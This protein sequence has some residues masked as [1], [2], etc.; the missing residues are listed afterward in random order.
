MSLFGYAAMT[1]GVLQGEL[2][3]K[4]KASL[5]F[6]MNHCEN[7]PDFVTESFVQQ[8]TD[9]VHV[10]HIQVNEIEIPERPHMLLFQMHLQAFANE[11][12]FPELKRFLENL[13]NLTCLGV[14]LFPLFNFRPEANVY[15]FPINVMPLLRAA[16]MTL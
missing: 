14:K 16:N 12:F 5:R 10:I 8:F 7:K 11:A 13:T 3:P 9:Y 1:E 15:A 4:L 6:V 2:I